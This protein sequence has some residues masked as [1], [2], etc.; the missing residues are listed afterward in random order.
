MTKYS[1]YSSILSLISVLGI[2][3]QN[4]RLREM[5]LKTHGKDRALFG[6]TEIAQLDIKLYF[7]L[8]SL[9][10]LILIIIAI[11]KKEVK[12]TLLAAIILNTISIVII[13]VRLWTYWV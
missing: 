1:K 7:G 13:F 10:S 8:I 5:F 2:I 3:Y 11:R 6:I 12:K 9:I 4:F